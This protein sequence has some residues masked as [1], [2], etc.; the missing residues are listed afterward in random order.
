MKAMRN[1]K[2]IDVPLSLI[3]GL[4]A[5]VVGLGSQLW[6][7]V[8]IGGVLLAFWVLRRYPPRRV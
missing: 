7:V 1:G 3:V 4:I 8:I 5:L 2:Q 6:G